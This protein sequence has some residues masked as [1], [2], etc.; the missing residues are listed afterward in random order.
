[1][2][3]IVVSIIAA[4]A[5]TYGLWK[6]AVSTVHEFYA[7]G[8]LNGLQEAT[9]QLSGGVSS[10]YEH[11]DKPLPE[12]LAKRIDDDKAAVTH[13]KGAQEKG[14]VLS[15]RLWG[16]GHELGMAAWQDGARGWAE[17]L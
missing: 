17:I 10:H 4:A 8:R 3:W 14:R 16:L 12:R 1:V 5:A 9:Q 11:E 6:A 13:A 15:Q 7:Q 2:D